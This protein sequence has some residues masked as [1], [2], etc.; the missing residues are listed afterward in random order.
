[1]LE[2]IDQSS[3]LVLQVASGKIQ[4]FRA[5]PESKLKKKREN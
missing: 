2:L 1:M 5:E 3:S 4:I